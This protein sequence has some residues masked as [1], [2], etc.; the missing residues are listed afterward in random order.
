MPKHQPISR[1]TFLAAG[2]GALLALTGCQSQQATSTVKHTE[3]EDDGDDDVDETET[4]EVENNGKSGPK[5]VFTIVNVNRGNNDEYGYWEM[6]VTVKNNSDQAEQFLGFHID[7]LDNNGNIIAS[8]MSY[9][10]NASYTVV[11]P[12]QEYTIDLTE[13]IDDGVCGM[14]SRYCEYGEEDDPTR[15][16]YST[17]FKQMF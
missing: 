5:D 1:R 2:A 4:A 3:N 13:S 9:N 10:K 7:E 15:S 6:S 14:Q 12:G 17:P 11:E 8:Y 16:D